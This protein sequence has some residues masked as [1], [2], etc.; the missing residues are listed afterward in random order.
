MLLNIETCL[1]FHI[2]LAILV[3]FSLKE[4]CHVE[5]EAVLDNMEKIFSTVR[6]FFIFTS[7]CIF[8]IPIPR[9]ICLKN[10]T[11]VKMEQHDCLV[12]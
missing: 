10:K 6:L 2:T 12:K 3:F 11:K 4:Y 9:C 5:L 7:Y 8:P 1:V